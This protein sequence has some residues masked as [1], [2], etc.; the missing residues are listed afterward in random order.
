[1]TTPRLTADQ[2]AALFAE[3]LPETGG[4]ISAK[5][6][7]WL[8]SQFA[9]E[10]RIPRPR[11]ATGALADGR[12]WVATKSGNANGAGTLQIVTV[13]ARAA[14]LAARRYEDAC[15][16]VNEEVSAL[17]FAGRMDEAKAL[18]ERFAEA[19]PAPSAIA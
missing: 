14:D 18:L 6:I 9:R 12:E 17:F 13:A 11:T 2:I 16:R 1:M 3:R 4:W 8:L 10:N 15:R 7:D 19:H 5:Q